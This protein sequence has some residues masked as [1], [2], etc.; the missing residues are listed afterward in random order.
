MARVVSSAPKSPSGGARGLAKLGIDDD[1]ARRFG[2]SRTARLRLVRAIIV[3]AAQLRTRL[4]RQLA[5]DGLTSQQAAVMTVVRSAGRPSFREVAAALS[6]S[7]QNVRQL[8]GVLLRKGFAR[9]VDDPRDARVKR[10]VAT[11][12][13]ARY[14]AARDEAD[15]REIFALFDPLSTREVEATLAS[16][17]KLLLRARLAPP[18]PGSSARTVQ[19]A[20]ATTAPGAKRAVRARASAK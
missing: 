9:V 5:D 1:E 2:R 6:T 3:L 11:A 7:P 16:L 10:L 12:K 19:P 20:P 17:Q 4:D 18:A 15:H 8:V 13:N 14:W